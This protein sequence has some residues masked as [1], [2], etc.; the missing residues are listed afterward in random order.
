MSIQ[1][2]SSTTTGAVPSAT[3]GAVPS[4]TTGA[5]PTLGKNDFLL[6]MIAQLKNQDPLS[7]MDQNQFLA[8]TAQFTSLEDLQNID[9]DIQSL[10]SAMSG[11]GLTASAGLVGHTVYAST[12][13]AQWDGQTP[14]PLTFT[15]DG[16]PSHVEVD[17]VDSQGS[18]VSQMSTGPLAAG[19]QQVTWNGTNDQGQ[20]MT[21]GTYTYRVTAS[22]A[23]GTTPLAYA[24]AGAVS[25]VTQSNGSVLYRIGSATVNPTDIVQ[26]Q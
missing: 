9:S 25:G 6:L 8:Q 10:K 11:S 12:G 3:T 20:G 13:T 17:V 2:I 16:S 4:A 22:G 1:A 26:I 21:P 23:P 24:T 5:G 7:P 14:A 19:T 18:I 15:V